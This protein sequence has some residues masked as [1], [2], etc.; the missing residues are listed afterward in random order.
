MEEEEKDITISVK[1]IGSSPPLQ[2]QVSPKIQVSQL[3]RLVGVEVNLPIERLKLFLHGAVL[4]DTKSGHEVHA[5]LKEGD[6][7]LAVVAPKPPAK[8]IQG[9]EE[10]DEDD[11]HFNLPETA[12]QWKKNLLFVLR[13]KL[14]VPDILLVTFF[15][16]S[17]KTWGMIF[18]WFVMSPIAYRWDL[19]P[20]YILSTAFSLM[21]FNL[22][23]RQQGD[24]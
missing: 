17:L 13:D 23:Q 20:L 6:M 4:H 16:I 12:A 2:L 11:L 24:A 9:A 5:N 10:D 14:R 8:H 1:K 22:G 15:S 7:L 21:F 19:G 18:L 3:R